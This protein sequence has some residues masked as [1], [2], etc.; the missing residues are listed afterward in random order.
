M[1][2]RSGNVPVPEVAKAEV[3]E[4]DITQVDREQYPIVVVCRSEDLRD[5]H[6]S[7]ERYYKNSVPAARKNKRISDEDTHQFVIN[8]RRIFRAVEPNDGCKTNVM[9]STRRKNDL[10][11]D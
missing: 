10:L 1:L 8:H 6:I 4:I 7:D 3:C 9:K 11:T 2:F 5:E